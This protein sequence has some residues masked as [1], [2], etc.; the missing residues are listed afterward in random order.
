MQ[1]QD[2]FG[3]GIDQDGESAR[4]NVAADGL[5]TVG[6]E[7]TD[8]ASRQVALIDT[9][10]EGY[11]AI[12]ESF[13]DDVEVITFA[14]DGTLGQLAELLGGYRDL[15]AIHLVSHGSTGAITL[16]GVAID[17][18]GLEASAPALAGIGSALSADG[19]I[20]LYGCD[21]GADERGR[22]FV[23][24][25]ASLTGADVAASDDATG[26]TALGGDWDLEVA[27]GTIEASDA[28]IDAD[29]GFTG[30]LASSQDFDSTSP[31]SD[32]T[33]T[34]SKSIGGWTFTAGTATDIVSGSYSDLGSYDLGGLTGGP[35]SADG[36]VGWN[37]NTISPVLT[38]GF[39]AADGSD[40][41]LESFDFGSTLDGAET[42]GTIKVYQD[43]S[44]VGQS[45]FDLSQSGGTSGIT[46]TLGGN[47]SSSSYYG[48]FSFDSTYQNVDEVAFEF[49]NTGTGVATPAID[50][51]AVSAAVEPNNAPAFSN[52][53]ATPGYTEDGSAVVLDTD[54]TVADTELDALNG[55]NGDYSGASL[56]V[57]R[58]GGANAE[59][60]LSFD[61]SGALFTVSGSNLQSGGLTFATF[62]QN[63]G[64]LAVNFTS[65]GT[66][67]TTS[68]VND[69]LQRLTYQNGSDAPPA[70][71][72]LDYTFNDGTTDS[73]GTNQVT[74]GITPTNDAPTAS[75]V[76]TNVTVTEDA[77][78][79]FDLSA[80]TLTDV[81][82]DS[83]TVTLAASAGS[84]A[85]TSGG[86][87][88]VGGSG[89]GSL[90]LAGTAA[91]INT[92][93]DT[94]SNVKYT[95]ASDVNGN[96]A[97][98]F[99]LNANDGSVNPQV[100]GGSIDITAV[101][102]APVLSDA[103]PTL[104]T[105]AED[106]GVP[107]N[108]S[109]A[110]STLVSALIDNG[111]SLDNF[112]DVDGDSAGIAVVGVNQGT[113]Y[114]STD[115]GTNWS[116]LT[117]TVSAS[118]AL[119]L[120]ADANTRVYFQ[121]DANVNGSISDAITFKAWDR[122][123]GTNGVT[124]ADTTAGSAFS[125]ATDTAAITVTAV[126]D[127]P[128]VTAS[129]GT[130]AFTEDAG[131]V[132]VDAGVTLG[133]IDNATL[134]SATVSITG[135]YA[136][137]SDVLAFINDD[138]SN[139]G[140]I[141]A[142]FASGTGVLTLT[143]A[144]ATASVAQFQNAMR[145]VTFDSTSDTPSTANRTITFV[146]ND[147]TGNS[148]GSTQTVS[149]AA[150]NDAPVLTGLNGTPS[151]TE[152]DPAVILDADVTVMDSELAGLDGGNGD[153]SGAT[154]NIARH[155]GANAVDQFSI[156]TGGNLTVAGSSISAG[157]N[158]IA[159]FDTGSAGQVSITFAN[160][161]TTPTTAL[162]NEVMQAVR[163]S[164]SANDPAGSVQ[165]DWTFSDAN[166]GTQ[167]SGGTQTA[168]G[169]TT[170]AVTNVNDAPT[171][172][173]TGQDPTYI[174]G[175]AAA[176]LFSGVTADTV[177]TTNA[178]DRFASMTLTVTNVSDGASEILTVDG[179]DVAL[180]DGNSVTTAANSLTVTV[181]VS[182]ATATV[183]FTGASLTNAQM[184]TLIDAMGYRNTS[185]NPTMAGNR[186]VTITGIQDDGGVA[187]GGADS[188]TPNLVST[189]SL[190]GVNDAPVI[191][192]VAG[193]TSQITAGSG[194]LNVTGL[195][196]ATLANVDSADYN[197]GS[198]T[199][200]QN[201]GTFNGSW[202]L[203]GSIATAGGDGA[204]AAG[205]TISIGGT[206]IG[207]VDGSNDGQGGNTL[208]I[209][210]N[211]NATNAAVLQLVRAL[212]YD[213]PSGLGNR[214]FM[215][216][217][218]DGDGTANGGA[219]TASGSFT[220]SV[221]PNPPVLSGLDGDS[222]TFTEGGSPVL[223][224]LSGNAT[225]T[226]ADSTD[227]NN[228]A[229][230]VSIADGG[231]AADDVLSLSTAG[232]VSLAGATAGST[233]SVG[234]TAVGTL[235]NNI[236][237]GND[238]VVHLDT[239]ATPARVQELMRALTYSNTDTGT[240]DTTSR[241]VT[242]TLNDGSGAVSPPS[243]V[244]VAVEAVNDAPVF[245][246]V[247]A[248][249]SFTEGGTAVVLDGDATIADPELD[250]MNG[251]AGNYAG[252]S[253]TLARQGGANADDEFSATGTLGALS[254]GASLTL[255]GNTIGTVTTNGGGTLTL[256][257]DANATTARVS[258]ALQQIAYANGSDAPPA[259][260]EIA[261]RF[262]DG[263][264]GAQGSGGALADADDSVT[265]T[266]TGVNDA[267]VFTTPTA[268]NVAENATAVTTLAASDA[269]GDPLLYSIT[270]GADAALF[271]LDAN[272]G[273]L[274][275]SDA[276]DFEAPK[277][278]DGENVYEV[279]VQ[280]DDGR[281]PATQT[282]AITVTD[283]DETPPS[284]PTP[285]TPP[286]PPSED[287]GDLF[288]G[289]DGSPVDDGIDTGLTP[290]DT[291][292]RTTIDGA[293][294]I[295]ATTT[296]RDTGESVDV[297]SIDPVTDGSREDD[298]A[299]TG[300]VDVEGGNG[301]RISVSENTGLLLFQ[302]VST[303]RDALRTVIDL[304]GTADGDAEDRDG[305]DGFL[306]GVGGLGGGL[307]GSGVGVTEV[308]PIT[309]TG[310]SHR[311]GIDIGNDKTVVVVDTSGLGGADGE[312]ISITGSGS[313][314]VRGSGSFDGS[315]PQAGDDDIDNV[316]GD[317]SSQRLFFG[318]GDDIIRGQGG[319]DVV[320]SDGGKDLLFGGRGNDTVSGGVD[321]DRLVG[322]SGND[323][324]DGG[325]GV[326]VARFTLDR[327]QVTLT[328]DA[329]GR[330]VVSEAN[331]EHDTLSGV[332]LLRFNDRVE[333]VE[334]PSL[335]TA[336]GFDE[337]FYLADNP[338]VAAAVSR[339]D[340][341]SGYEHYTRYGADEGRQG[342]DG[343]SGF[344][345]AFYLA[346]NPDV[347]AAV[348]RGDFASGY[349]HYERYGADEGR[350]GNDGVSG[351]DEDFYLSQNAD[352][353]A[354]VA[355]GEITALDHYRDYGAHEG[356]DPNALFDE[357]VYR[358]ANPDVD[359]AIQRGELDSGY[360]HY[361]AWGWQ[362]GR[363]PSAWFDLDAYLQRHPDVA[364]AGVEP[365]GHYLRYGYDEGRVVTADDDGLWG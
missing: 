316:L 183:G 106:P 118:S 100:G 330:L 273:A 218:D 302:R 104:T 338:D 50:N 237:A 233:V 205:E 300:D 119:L 324:L 259:S 47:V 262:S 166:G 9:S 298:D 350:E 263:N 173:A 53:N 239:N 357:R 311:I 288:S 230:T 355:R 349:E 86:G 22:D 90:T 164:N 52:L 202:G 328:R 73:I 99:T 59:D 146:A 360:Q 105:V 246:G 91:D 326:D 168:T 98:S 157:G 70:S 234:G 303:S 154:L 85:A 58:N 215:L 46:Y 178:V 107:S 214:I 251:G 310:G 76:P 278:Q 29:N 296:D 190:T 341:A 267:P 196:D 57:A 290:T 42:T 156:A 221:T 295:R 63:N 344:D 354:A 103:A 125:T 277:D 74:V 207:T 241:S 23:D 5:P 8:D 275:F 247:D 132:A 356:R 346:H 333:L 55:S 176:D 30:L 201:T 34:T 331:G 258:S 12:A 289:D 219:E 20:L 41:K 43:G 68:L 261:Y 67:A 191:G 179:S 238:L 292:T 189:V 268:L 135:N 274:T 162:V 322:G 224:D 16:G 78:S 49:T 142:S 155:G 334:A 308:R 15:Q 208:T 112:S 147:G 279:T 299:T 223:L 339:G 75:G 161:G 257:F 149:V 35:G 10:I 335:V 17:G 7:V 144:G 44:L 250:A 363:D 210:F 64:T 314:V 291:F 175:A 248:T 200:T 138:A 77:A 236:S 305:L 244:T 167:G 114:Y 4:E 81:D 227:F 21:V 212:T 45:S 26:A 281:D 269:D 327:D 220:I 69:V 159:S 80:L 309:S 304:D 351:F 171:L 36:A 209:A 39:K 342:N 194:A 282:L 182:G 137:G 111:G 229:L 301:V 82:G 177:E 92:Y 27:S 13:S 325:T 181:S 94:A 129:G 174:E 240:P 172:T 364:E 192:N 121:P 187:N 40:F 359:A 110:N 358:E 265:V 133:D 197:G 2:R 126:N 361:Q 140:N 93:L 134:A 160:N 323:T 120:N 163:Y 320:A 28:G 283:V 285:P 89:T 117:G 312:S 18:E 297:I 255:D 329:E 287:D 243:T 293:P 141:T 170:V 345:E 130:T 336:S 235:A 195:D 254:E 315:E 65:S 348:S 343:V 48:A 206:A 318:P 11:E 188:A 127:V 61:T 353:A 6:G 62:T 1:G 153:F 71:V 340:F 158:E 109:T 256:T 199:L 79:D 198:L 270:G 31:D 152:G 217:L 88:T 37:F 124:G 228:G 38:Y 193:D 317:D 101:N 97:A 319:D 115:G 266:L 362:E 284:P 165:L 249:P 102:D 337:A 150:V 271:S 66:T 128:T 180:T 280:A 185:D 56:T 231:D 365:L 260:V 204:I 116:Q 225:V 252:A 87:V 122:S 245:T 276:P 321:D 123:S 51:I 222:V 84:F 307:G 72:T 151:Y 25:F 108:G 332:E 216:D 294:A 352:V 83:L 113:L 96:G 95:G 286:T 32:T 264:G 232:N 19:D 33:G 253:L 203:D 24:R 3:N 184:Q 169:S 54:A 213:A 186:V 145:A 136:S 148:S 143:S 313:I 14:A 306:S 272:S 139:F 60:I 131:A 211:G 242:V 226:D 347:A